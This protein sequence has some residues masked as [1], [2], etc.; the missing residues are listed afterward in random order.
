MSCL[1]RNCWRSLPCSRAPCAMAPSGNRTPECRG[2]QTHSASAFVTRVWMVYQRALSLS[3]YLG[4]AGVSPELEA[5]S[6]GA[7]CVGKALSL[8]LSRERGG[9]ARERRE[10]GRGLGQALECTHTSAEA[11]PRS[12][13]RSPVRRG[14]PVR[15]RWRDSRCTRTRAGVSRSQLPE[16]LLRGRP[17]QRPHRDE[18][19]GSRQLPAFKPRRVWLVP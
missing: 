17:R 14:R 11:K 9:L 1:D 2:A 12:L 6:R 8:G 4:D 13:A 5:L 19:N 7:S 10:R 16:A 15:G 3:L 18:R